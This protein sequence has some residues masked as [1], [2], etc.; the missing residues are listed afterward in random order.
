MSGIWHDHAGLAVQVFAITSRP[1]FALP[2]I[3]PPFES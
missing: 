3:P 2:F 1:V